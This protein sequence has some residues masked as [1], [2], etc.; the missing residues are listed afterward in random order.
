[1]LI[2]DDYTKHTWVVVLKEK[3]EAFEKFN[4]FKT[5]IENQNN[6]KIVCKARH[7]WGV[8]FK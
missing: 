7:R 4:I 6:C 1:M 8:H 3:F 5:M 2:I